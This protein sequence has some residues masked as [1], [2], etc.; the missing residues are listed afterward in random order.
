MQLS[1]SLIMRLKTILKYINYQLTSFTEHDLH[2]PFVYHFYMEFIK[3]EYPFQDFIH[4]HKLRQQLLLNQSLIEF[5]D[6]GA[7]SKKL[8]NIGQT[9]TRKISDI[10]KH[11]I[12]SKKQAEFLYRLVNYFKPNSIIELGTSVGLTT[13][14]L[15]KASSSSQVYTIEGC[16]N[17]RKFSSL[18]FVQHNLNNIHSI[19]GNFNDVFP[20]LLSSLSSVDFLYIDG[21]HTFESTMRYFN[22]ALE[23]K[24]SQSI[25]I[26]DDIYWSDG[27]QQAWQEIS[28]HPEVT[29]SLDL[30]YMGIVFFRTEHK[31][32]EQF[33]LKF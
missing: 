21:N 23:K 12:A 25:F 32:K 4:L 9:K 5:T 24:T 26:F 14:Y 27:M 6:L 11:G 15:A 7:G 16:P 2:S 20:K 13:M 10:T 28:N 30:F 22:M 33:V 29:L 8:S 18:L 31:F 19:E 1:R 17:L 3:N